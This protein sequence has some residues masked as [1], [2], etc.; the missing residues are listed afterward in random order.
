MSSG[1]NNF[2]WKYREYGKYVVK[3]SSYSKYLQKYANMGSGMKGLLRKTSAY[4][5]G[6]NDKII[7][8]GHLQLNV[9][10]SDWFAPDC[11]ARAVRALVYLEE[12]SYQRAHSP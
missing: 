9:V 5:G 8:N 2:F 12:R 7:T 6:T 1:G 4:V 3:C 11:A 10:M